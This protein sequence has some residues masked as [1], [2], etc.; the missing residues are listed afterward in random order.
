VA[1]FLAEDLPLLRRGPGELP[2]GELH[3]RL[4]E[5]LERAGACFFDELHAAAGG[6]L[7]RPVLDALWDL[8]WS[9]EV[10]NDTPAAFRAYLRHRS[11]PGRGRER[12]LRATF[13]SRRQSPPAGVG[14][15]SRLR[16]RGDASPA[17][18]GLALATQLLARHG[19]VTREAVRSEG[20]G[21]GFATVYPAL[22]ALEEAG[23]ARR[24]YFVAGLGGLQFAHPEA[25]ERL[26]LVRD[27][28]PDGAEGRGTVLAA[29]D[30]ANPYGAALPWPSVEGGRPRRAAGVYVGLVDGALAAFLGRDAREVEVFLPEHEPDRS[31]T[32]RAVAEAIRD[33]AIRTGRS[34]IGSSAAGAPL[35]RSPVAPYLSAAGLIAWGPGFRVSSG[36]RAPG[37]R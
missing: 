8:V 1:L 28:A 16:S 15:W 5:A 25:L 13:R 3:D 12:R 14:R 23:R 20:I 21:G 17:E 29:T 26:R 11:A 19:V 27:G 35:G 24:G 10:T 33:W 18:R 9:G 32:G 30:P 4:R 2:R 36:D 22:K 37:G 6:G 34:V 7:V 31:R